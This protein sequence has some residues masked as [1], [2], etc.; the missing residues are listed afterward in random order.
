MAALEWVQANIETFGG[1]K[2][3]VGIAYLH[4]YFN[5]LT[6]GLKVTVFGESAGA[7]MTAVLFLNSPL[8]R[9]ARAAVRKF[10]NTMYFRAWF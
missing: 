5:G 9:L 10:V 3:K 1:D 7:I 4:P 6:A 8:E 2:D